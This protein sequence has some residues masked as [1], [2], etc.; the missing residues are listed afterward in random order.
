MVPDDGLPPVRLVCLDVDGTL[1][2]HSGE[3]A[4]NVWLAAERAHAAGVPLALC[5]GR[6]G[7][8]V[9]RAIAERLQP[10]GWHCFQNGASILHL[11]DGLSLSTELPAE[12][13]ALLV[14]RA[15]R[16]G[17]PLE[18]YSD[19][20]YVT[21]S[22]S[23]LAARHAG[24]L[25]LRF[26]PRPY[27]ALDG[28]VVRAQWLLVHAEAEAVL[29]E[30]HPGLVVSPSLAPTLPEGVFVNLTRTGID[31]GSAVRAIAAACD[32]SLDE[33]MYVGDGFNDTPALRIVGR[34]VAVANAEPAA[35][36][37]ARQ[38]VGDVDH[39]GA[40]EAIA[41]ALATQGRRA[42]PR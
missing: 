30:P 12:T 35:L 27:A 42:T 26:R 21:E 22:E 25:G 39:G 37:L 32:V 9:T 34:P 38:V 33:V 6:P 16:T 40:A 11:Q 18:L 7:F 5:S 3:V 29:A 28:A 2:G 20:D 41:L 14:A 19:H 24:L 15:R 8:G 31:K 4:P 13:V 17:R 36:A 10:D 23:P 1:V